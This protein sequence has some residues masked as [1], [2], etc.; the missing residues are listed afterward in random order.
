VL[1]L[2]LL[3]LFFARVLRSAKEEEV[4]ALFSKFGKVYDVNLFRAFQGAPTTRVSE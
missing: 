3:Q 2:L 4:R 1:L